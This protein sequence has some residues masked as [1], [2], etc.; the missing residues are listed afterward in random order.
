MKKIAALLLACVLLLGFT[1]ANA[2]KDGK[3]DKLT[4]GITSPFNGNF[5][6]DT[7]GSNISDQDVRGLIH[8]YS[9]VKWDADHGEGLC[10]HAAAARLH[11]TE[12]SNRS[13]DEHQQDQGRKR[14][15]GRKHPN[16]CRFPRA[17]RLPVFRD[18]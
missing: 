18:D 5:L 2:A 16:A 12:G 9:L 17:G 10:L 14:V 1:T 15:P 13:T 6:D 4:V 8:G 7:L 11:R 3:Y